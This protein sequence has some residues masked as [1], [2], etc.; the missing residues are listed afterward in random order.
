[1]GDELRRV[2]LDSCEGE[3]PRDVAAERVLR[4][5]LDIL[6]R[7][8]GLRVPQVTG[9]RA[10]VPSVVLSGTPMLRFLNTVLPHL[11][12]DANVVVEVSGE[13][14]PYEEAAEAPVIRLAVTESDAPDYTDW[15]DLDVSVSVAGQQV[16]LPALLA[17]LTRGRRARHSRQRHVVSHR[18]P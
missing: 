2:P 10:I 11:Q 15:F 18:P 1:M 8:A 12:D 13:P 16:P 4:S 14:I 6:D 5:G 3:I 17:A 9:G 7:V